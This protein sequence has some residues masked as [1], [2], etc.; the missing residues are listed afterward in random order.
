MKVRTIKLLS[1]SLA[2]AALVLAAADPPNFVPTSHAQSPSA[3]VTS[4]QIDV[5]AAKQWL[6]TKINLRSGEKL[7]FTA[8]GTITYPADKKHPDGRT[9]GP[10]GLART[11]G[12]LIHEYAVP[13][14][15]HGSLVGRL[16][17]S[18]AAQPFGIG[19]SSDY[20]APVA[21]RLYL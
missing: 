3:N 21:G 4:Y 11:F 6:D 7:R 20:E 15:G 9:F 10:D 13:D 18:D 14:A 2:C 1:L 8:T 19:A 12:D 16:G 5:D 17:D